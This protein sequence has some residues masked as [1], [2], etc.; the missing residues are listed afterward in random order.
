MKT[1]ANEV[2]YVPLFVVDYNVALRSGFAITNKFSIVYNFSQP[3][4]LY[5]VRSTT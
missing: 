3:F 4:E 1:I 2:N 5:V